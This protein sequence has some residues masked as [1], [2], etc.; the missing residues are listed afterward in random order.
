MKCENVEFCVISCVDRGIARTRSAHGVP[1]EFWRPEPSW[2]PCMKFFV[3]WRFGQPLPGPAGEGHRTASNNSPGV[4]SNRFEQVVKR[5]FP[6]NRS[7]S[8]RFEQLFQL[9][10]EQVSN[11]FSAAPRIPTD[12]PQNAGGG[13]NCTGA[14]CGIPLPPM[15]SLCSP[16]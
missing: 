1:Q 10:I 16:H 4:A 3:V 7:F 12:Y 15:A 2:D 11:N 9:R 8:N 6:F 13:K 5:Q 14:V